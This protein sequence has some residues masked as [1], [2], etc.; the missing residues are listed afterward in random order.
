MI[1]LSVKSLLAGVGLAAVLAIA[2]NVLVLPSWSIYVLFIAI[3]A[4]M[5]YISTMEGLARGSLQR[6]RG[7]A[8]PRSE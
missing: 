2:A 7:A 6:K 1:E 4:F 3:I 5:A 8:A